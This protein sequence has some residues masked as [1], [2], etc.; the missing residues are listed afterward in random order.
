MIAMDV[1]DD[2]SVDRAVREVLSAAGR[3]DAVVNN[4]GFG[5]LGAVEDTSL[6]E[7]KAQM[8]TNFFGVLR[9]C[10]AVLP[11]M[12]RQGRGHII[13]I[14]SLAGIVGLP[15][16][17]L[18]SA[19]K[20][21]LEGLSESLRLEVR[22]F[23]VRVVLVEPGDF[24]SEFPARRIIVKSSGTNPAYRDA[25]SRF[26][27][28]QDKDES[29]A[30]AAVPV[31]NLVERILRTEHPRARYAIGMWGQRIVVPLKR[32]LPQRLFEWAFRHALGL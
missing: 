14:S 23:G 8:E 11:T 21:A 27:R 24:Q 32:I 5:I 16:N 30:P 26:K 15:F 17:G 2:Q 18:Y 22:Q 20:F 10:R 19:S 29:N 25:F 1:D 28:G 12:R 4:A 3:L 9:V 7:A 31:A 13:N 6:E